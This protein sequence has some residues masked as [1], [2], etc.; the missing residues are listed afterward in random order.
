M[1]LPFSQQLNNQPTYFVEKIYKAH[2]QLSTLNYFFNLRYSFDFVKFREVAPKLHTIRLD[3]K[4]RWKPGILIHPVI[5]NRIKNKAL[6]FTPPMPCISTQQFMIRWTYNPVKQSFD[7][8]LVLI[9]GKEI[10]GKVLDQLAVNDG[11]NNRAEFF[12][13]FDTNFIGKIIHWTNL[14]Y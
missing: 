7:L 2:P 6:V 3:Q 1:L 9:D 10:K 8:P 12:Q 5:N 4:D 11:F 13:Y 14:R